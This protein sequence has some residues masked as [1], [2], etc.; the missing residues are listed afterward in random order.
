MKYGPNKKDNSEIQK[1]VNYQKERITGNPLVPKHTYQSK[2]P[3]S[4]KVIRLRKIKNA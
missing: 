2:F 3:K 4:L 1:K